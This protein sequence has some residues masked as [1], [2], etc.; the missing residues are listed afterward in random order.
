MTT[1]ALLAGTAVAL[2][3]TPPAGAQ[4]GTDTAAFIKMLDKDGDG[5]LSKSE[6][7][8]T[9]LEADFEKIDTNKDG[10]LTAAELEAFGKKNPAPGGG[11]APPAGQ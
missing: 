9:P 2:A 4:A 3:Q 1:L 6:V 11:G 10:K 8:G 5:V 7:A